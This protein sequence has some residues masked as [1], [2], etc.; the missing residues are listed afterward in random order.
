MNGANP[1]GFRQRF[2]LRI[3]NRHDRHVMEL[4]V[5]RPEL[6]DVEPPMHCRHVCHAQPAGDRQVELRDMKVD[7]VEV[8][9]A[10][11]DFFQHQHM[12]SEEILAD[13]L[14]AQRVR[15]DRVQPRCG[16]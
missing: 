7:H 14:E 13:A 4:P 12:W 11:C 5:Q 8:A 6:W 10:L 16:P 9:D 1:A 15:P 2:P 3:R